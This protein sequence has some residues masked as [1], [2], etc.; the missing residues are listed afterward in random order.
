MAAHT[1]NTHEDSHVLS[2]FVQS[3]DGAD[4]PSG[5]VPL[6]THLPSQVVTCFLHGACEEVRREAAAAAAVAAAAATKN[7]R[8]FGRQKMPFDAHS[9]PWVR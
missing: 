8:T 1:L 6:K 9:A 5:A 7:A 4:L 2:V 3:A